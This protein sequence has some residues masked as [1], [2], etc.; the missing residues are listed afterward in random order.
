MR[1]AK[2]TGE[3]LKLCFPR[4]G[5]P[6]RRRQLERAGQMELPLTHSRTRKAVFVTTDGTPESFDD[7][8][9]MTFPVAPSTEDELYNEFCGMFP[10]EGLHTS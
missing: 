6:T 4:R 2:L 9:Q 1:S 10:E 7:A 3:Q 8:L 5:R